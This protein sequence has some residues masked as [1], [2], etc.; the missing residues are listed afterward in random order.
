MKIIGQGH[1]GGDLWILTA[2]DAEIANLLGYSSIYVN[3]F[4]RDNIK[5]GVIIKIDAMFSQLYRLAANQAELADLA[6]R[7][8][9]YADLLA[10]ESPIVPAELP[11]PSEPIM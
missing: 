3:G 8:R 1:P 11:L 2:S 10:C 7:L 9:A 5:V 6:K 4:K